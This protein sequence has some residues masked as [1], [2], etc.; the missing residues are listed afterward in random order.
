VSRNAP[1]DRFAAGDTT[2]INASAI[3]GIKVF[4]ANGCVSCHSGP[5]FA[6]DDFHA[7]VVLPTTDLGHHQDVT[8]LLASAFNVNGA[9]SDDTTTNKLTGLAQVDGLKGQFRTKSLRNIAG[10]GPYMHA[11][12]FATVEDVIDFYDQ[13]GAPLSVFRNATRSAFS[14][15]PSLVVDTSK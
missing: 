7:L 12:Q 4:L 6:A 3:R 8:G 5:N 11:G 10:S 13:G 2:A 14:V 9:Y 1:F 15:A